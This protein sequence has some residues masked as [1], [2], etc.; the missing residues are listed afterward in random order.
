MITLFKILTKFRLIFPSWKVDIVQYL[1]LQNFATPRK[2]YISGH[3][4]LKTLIITDNRSC[5]SLII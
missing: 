3:F 1:C 2:N 4:H 5:K